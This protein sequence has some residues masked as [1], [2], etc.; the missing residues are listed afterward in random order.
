MKKYDAIVIGSGFAGATV[1]ERL[2]TQLSKKV[3]L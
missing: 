2:A 1:A 3:L